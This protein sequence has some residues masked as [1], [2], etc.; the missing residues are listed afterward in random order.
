[1][2]APEVPAGVSEVATIPVTPSCSVSCARLSAV[3]IRKRPP[4]APTAASTIATAMA[5]IRR[6]M[7]RGPGPSALWCGTG[8]TDQLHVRVV[9][10]YAIS[11]GDPRPGE[12]TGHTALTAGGARILP[13]AEGGRRVVT[14]AHRAELEPGHDEGREPPHVIF[15]VVLWP[16]LAVVHR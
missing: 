14:R 6:V 16:A 10:R 1:M 5:V 9:G 15:D 7:M 4:A 11:D 8:S 12:V 2:A 13:A 3:R